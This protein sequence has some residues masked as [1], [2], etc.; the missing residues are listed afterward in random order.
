MDAPAFGRSIVLAA[1]KNWFEYTAL[2]LFEVCAAYALFG[3]IISLSG[4]KSYPY[5]W[6]AGAISAFAAAIPAVFLFSRLLRY[7]KLPQLLPADGRS[8]R[9][10]ERT[11]AAAVLAVGAF[12]RIWVIAH[13]PITPA[14]DYETYYNVAVLLSQGTLGASGYSG[15]IA[16]FPHVIGYPFVLSLL[17]R[18]TGPSVAAG[19]WL[20]AAASLLSAFFVYRIT[21]RLAGRFGGFIALLLAA[22]WP[23]QI[24]YGTI[25]ASEP[26]FI[27]TL[28]IAVRLFI[29]LFDYPARLG[30]AES[31]M[32]LCVLFGIIVALSA[33]IRP[34]TEI[35]LAAAILCLLPRY[36][37]FD[38]NEKMLYGKVTRMAC[39]GW[40]RALVIIFS[41]LLCARLVSAAV[42]N[43]IDYQ[44]PGGT[45]SFGYNFMVGVNIDA[46]GAW[47]QKDADF[48][49]TIFAA[50]NS[51]EAAH[52]ASIGVALQRIRDNPAGVLNLAMEKFA[53]LWSNDDYASYWV[54]LFLGQQGNLTPERQNI[55][56]AISQWNDY[57]YL[58]SIFFS[59]LMGLKMIKQRYISP[60]Q[61][62]ILLFVG[63]V[64]LHMLLESQ[65]RYHYIMLP[66]FAILS[67]MSAADLVCGF[68]RPISQ[69]S[70]AL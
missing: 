59:S 53:Y 29:Y 32:V 42:A 57:A 43:T 37:K 52:R 15:Y 70:S 44:L 12:V 46:K 66:V 13:T 40:F 30:N 31:L 7:S 41:Y 17:F 23:S 50:T 61:V 47:N 8:S 65:N 22:F 28:L 24:L 19:L 68:A 20:N 2:I 38:A 5:L 69:D 45:V 51:A 26:V 39:Q 48:F 27:C 49:S 9:V 16:E 67:S 56:N 4:P 3:G 10:I 11:A 60:A 58:L 54:T 63:T 36:V 6:H 62:L 35:L 21:R 18:I 55:I 25:L 1:K 34:L 33:A 64:I 14:S